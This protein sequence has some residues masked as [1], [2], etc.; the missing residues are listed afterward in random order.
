MN[1]N[2]FRSPR[3]AAKSNEL[4]SAGRARKAAPVLAAL[5]AAGASMAFGQHAQV[6][7]EYAEL[8]G[9]VPAWANPE[10]SL[11]A[12]PPDQKINGLTFVLVRSVEK[13]AA[14]DA[15][16][17]EQQDPNS[18][19]YH[20][21]LT[22]AE[23]GERFGAEDSDVQAIKD[24]LES[25]NLHVDWVAESKDR[26]GVSGAAA[27]VGAALQTEL[28]Y[29]EAGT[30][31]KMAPRETPLLPANLAPKIQSIRGL[32]TIQDRPLVAR[33]NGAVSPR[34]AMSFEG[35]QFPESCGFRDHLRCADQ[36]DRQGLHDWC[37]R[38]CAR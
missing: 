14:F 12:V 33:R 1:F 25:Q 17:A 16:L 2:R 31:P 29:Y 36:R 21:W 18:Q 30:T 3:C 15:F 27:D 10:R 5:L 8:A 38:P 13:Q 4:R 20:H 11:G 24:W 19:N 22:P 34:P 9:H 28:D 7:S 37:R 32:Y 23:V 6:S 26:I 35:L